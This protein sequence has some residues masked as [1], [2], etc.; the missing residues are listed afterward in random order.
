M[1]AGLKWNFKLLAFD[2]IWHNMNI[3]CILRVVTYRYLCIVIFSFNIILLIFIE[4][5]FD[6]IWHI[7]NIICIFRVIT[8]RYLC[9]VIFSFNII[10]LIFIEFWWLILIHKGSRIIKKFQLQ[11][12][13]PTIEFLLYIL[14]KKLSSSRI[15]PLKQVLKTNHGSTIT[16]LMIL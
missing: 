3:I 11:H 10:L 2:T 14:I 16:L 13:F 9:I 7:V 1:H 6:T 5:A 4:F 15:I 8:Y 12:H